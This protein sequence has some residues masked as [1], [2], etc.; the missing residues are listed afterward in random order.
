[1]PLIRMSCNF[2]SFS[3]TE[4]LE[5]KSADILFASLTFAWSGW[6]WGAIG[7]FDDILYYESLKV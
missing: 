6:I 7:F 3:Q 4:V 1:M 2:N 5:S